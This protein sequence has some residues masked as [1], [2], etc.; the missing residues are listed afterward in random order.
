MSY[1]VYF[2]RKGNSSP[3][4]SLI[5]SSLVTLG[6]I[7]CNSLI[8][9]HT[10]IYA[11]YYFWILSL[12]LLTLEPC[13]YLYPLNTMRPNGIVITTTRCDSLFY[14]ESV[15]LLDH[16]SHFA[17]PLGVKHILQGLLVNPCST[18]SYG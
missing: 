14:L 15:P 3:I 11:R 12:L 7:M 6:Y 17:H 13:P 1:L 5:S 10:T 4:L 16:P 2:T 8:M 9:S 18:F